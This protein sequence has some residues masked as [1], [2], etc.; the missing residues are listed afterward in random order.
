M[1]LPLGKM[2]TIKKQQGS[3]SDKP[4]VIKNYLSLELFVGK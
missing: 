2:Q 3:K 1:M 4:P